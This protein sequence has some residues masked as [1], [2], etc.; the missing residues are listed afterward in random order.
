MDQ[1]LDSSLGKV[2]RVLGTADK[3]A[4]V[5]DKAGNAAGKI[6][7]LMMSLDGVIAN[8]YNPESTQ[9]SVIL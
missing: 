2:D 1:Q 3:A 7:P 5:A 6:A 9:G 4:G 8:S